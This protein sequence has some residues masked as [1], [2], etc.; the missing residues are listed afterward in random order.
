MKKLT[1]FTA[2]TALGLLGLNASLPPG[3]TSVHINMVLLE[4]GG[5]NETHHSTKFHIHHEQIGDDDILGLIDDEF[6]TTYSVINGDQ[7]A[8]SNFWDG[9]FSVLDKDG[10]VVLA[11][12]SFNTNGDHYHLYFYATNTIYAATEATNHGSIFSVTDGSLRYR[13]GDGTNT[14]H[15]LGFTTVNDSYFD[16]D[17]NST[18]SYQLSGG[19]GSLSF[20]EEPL[21][22]ILTGSAG[23]F[24]KDNAPAP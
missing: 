18:E 19:I 14:F 9:T 4:Q 23:G 8:I 24:G 3:Y 16:H 20:P 12:A 2:V 21:A 5:T 1:L 13:S 15:L 7:L 17:T 22:G 6:G 11:N 10:N